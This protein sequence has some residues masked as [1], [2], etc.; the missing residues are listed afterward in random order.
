VKVRALVAAVVACGIGVAVANPA[1]AATPEPNQQ[2]SGTMSQA[3]YLYNAQHLIGA[4]AGSGVDTQEAV[5]ISPSEVGRLAQV[6]M[7]V[8]VIEP[9]PAAVLQATV[10]AD[11][12]GPF[13]ATLATAQLT[14]SQVEASPHGSGMSWTDRRDLTFAFTSPST[15]DV[16]KQYWVVFSAPVNTGTGFGVGYTADQANQAQTYY[17]ADASG[18]S[19]TATNTNG[20]PSML[21][22]DYIAAPAKTSL[23][24]T[25]YASASAGLNGAVLTTTSGINGYRAV[26][27]VT[28]GGDPVVG[29]TVLFEV[30]EPWYGWQQVCTAVTNSKGVAQCPLT[31]TPP[32]GPTGYYAQWMG[33]SAYDWSEATAPLVG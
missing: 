9:D 4:G 24:V 23:T 31:T 10:V 15:I 1:S 32:P 3:S 33:D 17:Y 8:D 14:M 5:L 2:W 29:R 6:T 28:G 25:P 27:T 21:F 22:A 12:S 13:G 16:T 18:H 20:W 11:A 26:L 7:S 19:T 30:E